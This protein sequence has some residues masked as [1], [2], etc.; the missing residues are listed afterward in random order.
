MS[1]RLLRLVLPALCTVLLVG[2]CSATADARGRKRA[3]KVH[4]IS[5]VA[6][7]WTNGRLKVKWRAVRGA[8][9]QMRWSDAPSRLAASPVVSTSTAA[10]TYTGTGLD[11]GKTWYVQARALKGAVVGPWSRA[12]G[13]KFQ[14]AWPAAPSMSG[15]GIDGGVRF[16][17]PAAA[18]ATN[19]RLRWSAAWYGQWPGAATYADHTSGG[20]VSGNTRASTYR[21]P[22]RPGPGDNYLAVEYANPVFGQ[23]EASNA[24]KAGAI[25]KSPWVSVFPVAPV[26]AEGDRLRMG[27]YNVMLSPT[28]SRLNA[29]AR[30]ISTHHVEVVTIQEASATTADDLAGALGASTWAAVPSANASSNQILY[31]RDKFTLLDNDYYTVPNPKDPAKPSVT[32]WARLARVNPAPGSQSFLVSAVH[33]SEDSR[34]TKLQQNRDTGLAAKAAMQALDAVNYSREPVIVAGDLRYGR[35]PYGDPAGYTAAQP[36]FVRGGY[37]DAM[38]SR[39][40]S[41]S[42][43]SVVNNEGGVL[44]AR[45]TPHPSGLGPR[46]DHILMKGIRG[47]YSYVNVASWSYNGLVPSDHNLIYTDIAVPWLAP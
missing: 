36:T 47:S 10:G 24:Y 15:S 9:Y 23:L 40:R 45:Q 6:Q 43:Y 35:E 12:R 42:Q 38:A 4:A 7:D 19:Y 33:F 26:P 11:R 41:G 16:V 25:R 2:L 3:P 22:E 13:L 31:R 46:S 17:W 18:N 34:K 20:W 29:I 21:V 28:G 14:H 27:N 8:R 1:R 39:S 32:P 37:Y 44:R 30:N 5:R